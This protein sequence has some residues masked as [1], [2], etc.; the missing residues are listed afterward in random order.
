MKQLTIRCSI[1]YPLFAV[2]ALVSATAYAA[3]LNVTV[4]DAQSGEKLDRIS[5]TVI[6]QTGD[7]REGTSDAMG[8]SQF[9]E[10]PAGIYAINASSLSYADKV[11]SDVELQ[12]DEAKSVEIALFSRVI[13]LDQVSVTASRRE[14]KVLEAPAAVSVLD[15]TQID[16]RVAV[17]TTEHFK[18]LPAVDVFNTGITQSNVTVRGFS[19]VFSGSLLSLVDN[20]IA[21]VPS[22]RVNA[23]NFIPTPQN[24]IERV[25]VVS[26]PGSALYGPNS[27][28]GVAHI[29]TKSP[30]GSEGTRVSLGAGER[31]VLMGSYRHAGS[32]NNKI[33]YKLTGRYT[34]GEDWNSTDPV[35]E[36][37]RQQRIDAGV[38]EEEIKIGARD[39]DIQQLAGE[40]RV[41]YRVNEDLTTIFNAGYTQ[42]SN[43]ELTGIGAGQ[44]DNWTYSYVQARALYKDLFAQVFL[45]T[46]DAG[47]TFLLRDGASIIDK[48]SLFVAQL[49]HGL[50]LGARERLTYGVDAL[51]TRP[52]TEGSITGANEDDDSIN[53][54]GL[55]LQSETE[56]TDQ[57]RFVA[58]ARLDNHNRLEN[59]V[60]SPRAALVFKPA[61]DHNVRATYNRAFS[62][63]N[64]NNLFLDI[65]AAEDAFGLGAAFKGVL[66]FS[67]TI[68]VRAQAVGQ[69]GF[70]FSRS[71][72]GRPQ[73]RSPF[74]PLDP[75]GPKTRNDYY[76][77]DDP[78]FTNVMWGVARGAVM[79][80]LLTT[81]TTALTAQGMPPAQIQA[82]SQA[83]DALVPRQVEGVKNVMR[84]LD[85]ETLQF[86]QVDDAFDV[87]PM[88]PT[89]TQTFELGYKG[90][91]FNKLLIGVDAYHTKIR[92]FVG[93]VTPETPNVFLDPATL[94]VFLGSQF[95]A[96]LDNPQNA[97]LNGA[98][99]A[100]LDSPQAGGNG[101]GSAA[102]E[103]T[104]LFVTNG[105]R[106]PFGTVTPEEANDPVAVTTTYRNFGD[107][108]LNGADFK[109][110]YFLN[111]N[112]NVGGNYSYVS[113]NLFENVDNLRDIALNAPSNKFGVSVEYLNAG[114][115]NLAAQLRMRFV[116]GFPV[117]SGVYHGTVERYT[118]FDLSAGYGLP[119]S[120]NTRL[121]LTI[122]NLL[123]NKHQE[124]VGVPEI[125]RLSIMRVTQNF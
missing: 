68:D 7:S 31:G 85:L 71:A 46:N 37:L 92:D 61:P 44:A 124:F 109:F 47:D 105:G 66:P 60:F 4:T 104:T 79:K 121:S 41:D 82:L 63:P 114:L 67:P 72:D 5:I 112:W 52:N 93:P 34:Q 91:L 55:Y 20:R 32:F 83:F 84:S 25:E 70:H 53:E 111:E 101:N 45:N 73:F 99:V 107:I 8:A 58:A 65:R 21:S 2:L 30:F 69:E 16:S 78:I 35:E 75:R 23:Y 95:G 102:D 19:N 50:S 17:T 115:S 33:G 98:L 38:P 40:A 43:I 22:L 39:F 64:T 119:F 86:T 74:A 108:S 117:N 9:A 1:L 87:D 28:N 42:A 77:L 125:G 18:S 15:D 103:L 6:P 106:I 56:L 49:Q 90:T 96:A 62:T 110:A 94:G 29:I 122:Q 26:G 89:I 11:V 48:S 36:E 14:E 27:A 54:I 12:S 51:L 24:D 13:Q 80:E 57:L 10:L 3:T 81:A 76:D 97:I 88:K 116:D 100:L 59:P 113:K 120:P 118:T 123:D